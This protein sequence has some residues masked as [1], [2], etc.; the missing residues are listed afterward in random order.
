MRQ[1]SLGLTTIEKKEMSVTTANEMEEIN[2]IVT[3]KYEKP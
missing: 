3:N 1:S 2:V